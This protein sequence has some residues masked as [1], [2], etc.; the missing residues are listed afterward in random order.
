MND[1]VT[2]SIAMAKRKNFLDKKEVLCRYLR[3]KY[4]VRISPTELSYRLAY[5]RDT[6]IYESL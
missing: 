2:H 4:Q 3:M 1:K 6:K 5:L